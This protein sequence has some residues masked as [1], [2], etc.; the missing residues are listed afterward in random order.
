MSGQADAPLLSSVKFAEILG[1]LP[2]LGIGNVNGA[3]PMFCNCAVCG[4]SLLVDPAGVL[5]KLNAEGRELGTSTTRLL[6]E[7]AIYKSPAASNAMLM[8][9]SRAKPFAAVLTTVGAP[10]PAGTST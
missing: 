10:P 5:T 1:L 8:G 2:V 3:L 6:L 7:S 4:L 9:A